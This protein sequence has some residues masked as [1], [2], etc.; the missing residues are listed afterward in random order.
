MKKCLI[1]FL[2]CFVLVPVLLFADGT[3]VPYGTRGTTL[4]KTFT[5]IADDVSAVYW[6]PAGL[7]Q[8]KGQ[9]GSFDLMNL[10]VS[11][12]FKEKTYAYPG[13]NTFKANTTVNIPNLAYYYALD[14]MTIAFGM[15]AISGVVS[16]FTQ[17][18]VK[19]G[20]GIAIINIG[21]SIGYKVNE[22]LS[23]GAGVGIVKAM[24]YLQ[25]TLNIDGL[26]GGAF[27]PF[28]YGMQDFSFKAEGL[29]WNANFGA[30]YKIEDIKIGA[31]YRL[32]R[33]IIMEGTSKFLGNEK[34][35][36]TFTNIPGKV[37]LGAA[38]S[39]PQVKGLTS[40]LE[41][42]VT[43]WNKAWLDS[44]VDYKTIDLTSPDMKDLITDA[45]FGGRTTLN[46][47]NNLS[48]SLG[49]EYKI[50]DQWMARIGL[51]TESP[52]SLP[53]DKIQPVQYFPKFKG[54]GLGGTYTIKNIGI[55]AGF[56][57][58]MGSETSNTS[59]ILHPLLGVNVNPNTGDYN[60]NI[61]IIMLGIDVKL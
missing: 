34:D 19:M 13:D 57:R 27:A 46:G 60:R 33:R 42:S 30:L 22:D 12:E 52:A 55:N 18:D 6:N 3:E 41:M 29:S 38:Y 2:L 49:N 43:Q 32:P 25:G 1:V 61:N 58:L 39:W 48:V 9:G 7:T 20:A 53:G 31:S 28:G 36:T 26:A 17:T 15:Y 21:P 59:E 5:A 44:D 54:I 51:L 24:N 40:S 14:K 35:Y 45:V 50:N 16:D 37:N 47:K 56:V 10:K 4:G 8:L 11:G 23:I